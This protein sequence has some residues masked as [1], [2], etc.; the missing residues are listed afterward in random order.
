MEMLQLY[1]GFEC[2]LPCIPAVT[3]GMH[4]AYAHLAGI[5]L[6]RWLLSHLLV[7]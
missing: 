3:C 6:C 5:G 1:E 2:C 7:I 4:S